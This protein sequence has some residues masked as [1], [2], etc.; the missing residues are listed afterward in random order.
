MKEGRCHICGETQRLTFEHIPPKICNNDSLAKV[1]TGEQ[2]IL[3]HRNPWEI[4]GLRYTIQQRGM[5]KYVLCKRCNNKTGSWYI[6]AFRSFYSQIPFVPIDIV[7][8]KYSLLELTFTDIYPL[9]IMKQIVCMFMGINDVSIGDTY[10][11]I[12]EFVLSRDAKCLD[13]SRYRFTFFVRRGNF[14][15]PQQMA[16]TVAIRKAFDGIECNMV[17]YIDTETVELLFEE[18]SNGQ[19]RDDLLGVDLRQFAY[20]FDYDDCVTLSVLVPTFERNSWLPY[21]V[22]TQEE[23]KNCVNKNKNT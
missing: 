6:D 14:R 7:D 13:F 10:P 11:E 1:M 8:P 4:D 20:D 21:D 5:G 18:K 12:R 19:L 22:R 17:S 2:V 9:R 3:S 15:N 16:K 23:I